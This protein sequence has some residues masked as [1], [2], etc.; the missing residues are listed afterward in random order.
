MYI[1]AVKCKGI[2][3]FV[4]HDKYKGYGCTRTH[5]FTKE[6][7]NVVQSYRIKIKR[8]TLRADCPWVG[9]APA[10]SGEVC[11]DDIGG[12]PSRQVHDHLRE[13]HADFPEVSE[14]TVFNLV[15][16]TAIIDRLLYRCEVI[17]LA[18]T[19]YRLENRKTIF[20]SE[21]TV[22][23]KQLRKAASTPIQTQG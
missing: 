23:G 1:L 3:N 9:A 18:G 20:P 12:V 13:N 8:S 5:E 17:K 16:A 21:P 14:K 15:L 7:R 6:T 10:H 4:N 22:N 19:S 2:H 11:Q